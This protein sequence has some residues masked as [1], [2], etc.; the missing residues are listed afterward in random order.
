[1]I[2]VRYLLEVAN[3]ARVEAYGKYTNQFPQGDEN[4]VFAEDNHIF[5]QIIEQ[6]GKN[7]VLYINPTTKELWYEY[8]DRP[9]TAEE[10][11]QLIKQ[12]NGALKQSQAEQDALIMQLLLGGA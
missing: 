5:P 10:E 12:E 2:F 9:L 7:G 11:L 6:A 1:M 3:K 4:I 8:V